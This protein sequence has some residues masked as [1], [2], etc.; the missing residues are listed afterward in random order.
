M[1][2]AG[3][4]GVVEVGFGGE[5]GVK[6][7]RRTALLKEVVQQGSQLGVEALVVFLARARQGFVVVKGWQQHDAFHEVDHVLDLADQGVA[8]L[9]ALDVRGTKDRG[10]CSRNRQADDRLICR[11]RPVP[12][13]MS[14]NRVNTMYCAE[15]V[16]STMRVVISRCSWVSGVTRAADAVAC[17][18]KASRALK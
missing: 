15:A 18:F 4:T 8:K 1:R 3:Q 12:L 11:L 17:A 2:W 5:A 10:A 16:Y 13:R 9:C 6:L 14:S 7:A